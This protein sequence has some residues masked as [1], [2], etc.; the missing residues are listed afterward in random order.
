MLLLRMISY[1]DIDILKFSFNNYI[2]YNQ[3]T[4][5]I[6]TPI[7]SFEVDKSNNKLSLKVNKYSNVHNMLYNQIAYIER[8]LNFN[9]INTD[10]LREDVI[11]LNIDSDTLFF[12]MNAKKVKKENLIGN[13]CIL[14][15]YFK[16]N[17][18]YVRQLLTVK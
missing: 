17:E 15:F 2:L 13:K 12:D 6:K 8:I 9:N 16:N 4:F 14:S 18:P 3:D 1:K 10:I 7:I 5:D 11:L